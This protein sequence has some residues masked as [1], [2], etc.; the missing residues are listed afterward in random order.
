MLPNGERNKNS[1][2]V[3]LVA[4]IV[5]LA[6]AL[7]AVLCMAMFMKN[8]PE[9]GG[10]QTQISTE[11]SQETEQTVSYP[12][13]LSITE[14]G[15][16]TL[17]TMQDRLTIAGISDPRQEL[18]ING[19][20]VPRQADGSFS[21]DVLLTLGSNEITVVHKE[22][23]VVYT[24]ERRYA[25]ESCM[26]MDAQSYSS[27]ATVYF[28]VSARFGSTV[29]V[30]FNGQ[31][32]TLAEDKFQAGTDVSEG[33]VLYTGQYVLPGN[34]LTDVDMGCITYTAICDGITETYT[35]GNIT[36]LKPVD[37]LASDPDATPDYGKYI[38][39]GSGYIAQIVTYAGETFNGSTVDDYSHPTNIYLP[40]GTLDYCST[41]EVKLGQLSY[42]VLRSGQR[43]Y[44]QKRNSPTMAIVQVVDRYIGQ[45]PD[46]NEIEFV[47]LKN[48]GRHT[49]LTLDCLWKAPFYFD[50]KPQTYQH[51]TNSGD[52]NYSVKAFTAEYIDITFCYATKFTGTV[53]VAPGDPADPLFGKIELISREEDCTLRL[54]LKEKGGFYGWDAYYNDDDQLCFR[55]LNPAKVSA[56]DN[57]IG[58]DLTGVKVLIDVG[59][60]GSDPG[61]VRED[62]KGKD[63][64]EADRNLALAKKLQQELEAA[65]A[66]VVLTRT[67]DVRLTVDERHKLLKK[68]APDYCISIHHNSIDGYPNFG[69]LETFYYTPFSM[70]AADFVNDRGAQCGVYDRA[71]LNWHVFFLARNTV[72]P[73]VLTENGYMSCDADLDNTLDET[74]IA[75]KALAMAKG[76]ADYFLEINK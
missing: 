16:N 45:L 2:R 14:P 74:A 51:A 22:Q 30:S 23:T 50:I 20:T 29:E 75:K 40:A 12:E 13:E 37:I 21:Y 53:T 24:V 9:E 39:V 60:G 41:E 42:V 56:S 67:T 76:V 28:A 65:G 6:V 17:L 8:I 71:E 68:E 33:F 32:I 48:E 64:Y 18:T 69:G 26:P 10:E 38:N 72:C 47:S 55:F 34:N 35:S 7:V 31:T 3:L 5:V 54:H 58:A 62:Y 61:T 49:V 44:V 57:A 52:R 15:E 27:G 4:L 43:L 1:T 46:H 11:T 19:V 66:T 63:V 36:C 59:H 25:V 73:V 70:K